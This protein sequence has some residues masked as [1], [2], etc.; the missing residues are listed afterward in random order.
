MGTTCF[1]TCRKYNHPLRLYRQ[2]AYA[3][4][5]LLFL[6]LWFNYNF[7]QETEVCNCGYLIFLFSLL[8]DP[9]DVISNC[10]AII[11]KVWCYV[12]NL[13]FFYNYFY[14]FFLKIFFQHCDPQIYYSSKKW[15]WHSKV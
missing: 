15:K 6:L 5:C 11:N 7:D 14:T 13:N 3:W 9:T 2:V 10:C 4:R 1:V 8:I 12:I